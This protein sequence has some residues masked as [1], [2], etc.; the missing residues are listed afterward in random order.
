MKA[1]LDVQIIVTIFHLHMRQVQARIQDFE[2][3]CEFSPPQSEK[4]EKSEGYEKRKKEGGSEKGGGGV[5]IHPFHLS[6][7]CAWSG[8]SG[9]S[10]S[11]VTSVA[12][13]NI[14]TP[15]WM[16]CWSIVGLHPAFNSLVAI[17]VTGWGEALW[18]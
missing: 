15:P 16:A 17:Y 10:L 12:T 18:E 13:R 1:Q 5:K 9:W 8:P 2:M 11:P 7:I 14:S 4:S 3:G 6:W